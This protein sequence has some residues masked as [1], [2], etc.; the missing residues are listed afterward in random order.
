MLQLGPPLLGCV[1]P[2]IGQ[3]GCRT[4]LTGLLLHQVIG[5]FQAAGGEIGQLALALQAPSLQPRRALDLARLRA[6]V[7]PL[8]VPITGV[9]RAIE[10][11]ALVD[12][13][14]RQ[15]VELMVN[16]LVSLAGKRER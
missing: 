14:F 16:E 13:Q 3:I 6:Q 7:V 2:L 4:E 10:D 12:P 9:G 5:H 8:A 11:G 15:R 1:Q